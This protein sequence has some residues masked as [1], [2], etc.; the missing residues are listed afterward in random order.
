[1]LSDQGSKKYRHLQKA[2]HASF[3]AKL[4]TL[5]EAWQHVESSGWDQTSTTELRQFIHRLAG[6]AAIYGFKAISHNAT[7][8]ETLLLSRLEKSP[9]VGPN[10]WL[11]TEISNCVVRLIKELETGAS[12]T[13][14]G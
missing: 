10:A 3:E 9:K 11:K 7:E 5:L 2:Y 13:P 14:K 1:M 6:S 12:I 8:L 4:N